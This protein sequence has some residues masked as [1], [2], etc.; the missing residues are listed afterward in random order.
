MSSRTPRPPSRAAASSCSTD[1]AAVVLREGQ[2][3]PAPG[4]AVTTDVERFEAVGDSDLYGGELLP[5]AR[6]LTAG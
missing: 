5:D 3:L 2:V 6:T 1:D 4:A